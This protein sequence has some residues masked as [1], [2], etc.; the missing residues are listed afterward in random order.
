MH[1]H[2]QDGRQDRLHV[3]IWNTN[4]HSLKKQ[5]AREE[6]LDPETLEQG[7]KAEEG[8]REGMQVGQGSVNAHC[9]EGRDTLDPE[10]SLSFPPQGSRNQAKERPTPFFL[11][12]P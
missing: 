2:L 9:L 3:V 12:L 8:A 4:G 10:A 7:V 5:S 6:K 11:S 1:L